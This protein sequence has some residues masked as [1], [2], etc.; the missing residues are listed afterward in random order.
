V[1]HKG[2][3]LQFGD[4]LERSSR[5]VW[6][7]ETSLQGVSGRHTWVTGA[8]FQQDHFDLPRLQSLDYRFSSPAVFAQDEISFG[9]RWTLAA[10]GRIDVHSEYG[11]L[12]TPRVSLLVRPATGWTLRVAGGTGAF[13]PTPFTEETE[14]TGLS[15]V[16]PL[17]GVRAEHARGTSV[18]LTRV[19]GP[20]EVTGTVFGSDV[21][22]PLQ[23]RVVDANH[24]ALVN[25]N[26]PTRTAGTEL[27]VRF[28]AGEFN[29]LF[30][31]GWTRSTE[32]DPD[33]GHRR[34]VPLTPRQALSFT[35]I[36]E[37]EGRGRL[38]F[39]A[40]Y[41]GRQSL[42]ENPYRA[43]GPAYALIGALAERRVGR[44]SLFVNCENLLNV[45][46]TQY[47]P[48]VLSAPR[49][50]GR[51]TVD[52]WAPLN[53]RVANGGDLCCTGESA[54]G[55][56]SRLRLADGSRGRSVVAARHAAVSCR[57]AGRSVDR[58]YAS[59]G[60]SKW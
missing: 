46:Q 48:L 1:T 59:G 60:V 50:D 30:T 27:L 2:Q 51:W 16:L 9:P 56:L 37:A 34:D 6:F 26:G 23:R 12:A 54:I 52:A 33:D 10:S 41:T 45:R 5:A 14:E 32:I 21:D 13:A 47:D 36:W 11:V 25:V 22:D 42:E 20:W 19:F 35:L 44:V 55:S 7:G 31:H 3:D 43:T 4:S 24:V 8:A 18:D 57:I 58:D 39:E 29:A 40:Y 28:R 49:P 53:G 17:R 15:R 38:G